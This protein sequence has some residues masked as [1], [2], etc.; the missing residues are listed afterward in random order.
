VST[1]Q[2]GAGLS[3]IELRWGDLG[4]VAAC[5]PHSKEKDGPP[6]TTALHG[7]DGGVKPPLQVLRLCGHGA[8]VATPLRRS[9]R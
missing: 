4:K 1:R 8:S 7:Q 6:Q 5:L 3:L 2:A 9:D